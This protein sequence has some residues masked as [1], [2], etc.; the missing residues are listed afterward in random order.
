MHGAFTIPY[1]TLGLKEK[2]QSCN[3][4]VW[5][6]FLT[7]MPEP[8][9]VCHGTINLNGLFHQDV[10]GMNP[11]ILSGHLVMCMLLPFFTRFFLSHVTFA[12]CFAHAQ[13][14]PKR[15][16]KKDELETVG[17]LSDVCS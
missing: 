12:C 15:K 11:E 5:V 9:N 14:S 6:H 13:P 2:D 3:H 10:R 1:G 17:E 16:I 7:S 8:V 4:E